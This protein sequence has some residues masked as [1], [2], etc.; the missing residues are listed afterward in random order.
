MIDAEALRQHAQEIAARRLLKARGLLAAVTPD[1]R[2][3]I[4][5]TAYAVAAGVADCLLE[6]AARNDLL[7]EALLRGQTR[8]RGTS[9]ARSR[10]KISSSFS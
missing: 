1:E 3:A 6:E 10:E 4:E 7:G 9:K 2:L 5:K 8:S